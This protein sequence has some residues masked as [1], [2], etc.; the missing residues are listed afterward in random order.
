MD[1]EIVRQVRRVIVGQEEVLEQIMIGLFVGGHCLITGLPGTTER[2]LIG[3]T[4][5]AAYVLKTKIATYTQGVA[6]IPAYNNVSAYSVNETNTLGF[7]AYKNFGFTIGTIDTY[8]NNPAFSLPP[9]K[10]NSFQFTMGLTYTVKSK[11]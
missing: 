2:N 5:A 11:Y 10:R 8:L 7:P 3:S 6:Y 4:F 1:A 9:T